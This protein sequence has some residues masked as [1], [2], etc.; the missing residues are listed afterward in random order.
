MN[1]SFFTLWLVFS[2]IAA[3]AVGLNWLAVSI[4]NVAIVEI[5]TAVFQYLLSLGIFPAV[6]WV[7]M[8]WQRAFLRIE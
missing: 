4:L 7:F 3:G 2:L 5:H 8:R 6:A 1:K